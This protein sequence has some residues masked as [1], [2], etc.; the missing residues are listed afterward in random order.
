MIKNLPDTSA[1]KYKTKIN[2]LFARDSKNEKALVTL[3]VRSAFDLYFQAKKFPPGSEVLMTGV[4]IPDMVRI[5]EEH[6]CVPV[7][8]DLD[9][10]TMQPSLDQIKAATG[11]KTVCML[12]GFIFGITYD[13]APFAD[14]LKGRNIDIIEDCAQSFKSLDIFRGSPLATMTLFSFG[15]I[16]HNTAFYGAVTIIRE[17]ANLSN[18]EECIDLHSKMSKI[19]NTYRRYSRED[20]MKKVKTAF[21]VWMFLNSQMALKSAMKICR[22]KGT[23]IE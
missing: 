11:E 22:M 2:D 5:I 12:F 16:K 10:D 19:Q 21:V 23:D 18:K 20:Y 1:E 14:F 9:V 13:P 4:N 6:G 7:P 17:P 3:S 15:T 8:V